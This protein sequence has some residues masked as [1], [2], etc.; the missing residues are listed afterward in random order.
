[1]QS[2]SEWQTKELARAFLEGV[3]G[4]IPGGDLQLAVIS[5][6]AQRWSPSPKRIMDLGCGDGIL[7]HFL[8]KLFPTASGLLLDFSDPML[9]AAIK[10]VS[11][12]PDATVAKAD[13]AS[14][15][16]LDV[17]RPHGRFDI[18]ISGFAIHH[19]PDE[20]KRELYAE[21]YELLAPG[22]I[23]LNLEHVSSATDAGQGLFDDFFVDHLFDFHTKSNTDANR[24]AIAEEYYK[25]PDKKENILASVEEQCE[26]LRQFG[27]DDV[28][29]FFKVF[30][31]AIF[32]GRKI[33]KF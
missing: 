11:S 25:R 18:V 12:L 16:W 19:Q 24:D 26:W 20:R 10:K 21:I 27:F 1:M 5:K 22:G 4:A 31:L 23:F 7:G 8:L 30:E 33:S 13:F 9:D 14:P 32:G 17:A 15:Q 2:K 6:I 28:D 29:C 3:R